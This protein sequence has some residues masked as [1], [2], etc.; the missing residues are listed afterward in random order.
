MSNKKIIKIKFEKLN[1]NV[2]IRVFE[3]RDS[4]LKK[5][6]ARLGIEPRISYPRSKNHSSRPTDRLED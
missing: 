3:G 6:K 1:S 5:F 2:K 4:K